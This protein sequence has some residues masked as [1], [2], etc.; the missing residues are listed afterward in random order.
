M[1]HNLSYNYAKLVNESAKRSN[2]PS[3]LLVAIV[4]HESHWNPYVVNPNSSACGLGQ[5]IPYNGKCYLEPRMN[6]LVSGAILRKNYDY[7]KRFNK[8][9][10]G[11]WKA[12]LAGYQT[13]K[14]KPVKMT[15]TVLSRWKYLE[16]IV[17]T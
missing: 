4:E 5:V 9:R 1:V 2:I 13:G 6:L 8:R 17:K 11:S 3:L 12:G 7:C 15:K 14:C 16:R 10:I